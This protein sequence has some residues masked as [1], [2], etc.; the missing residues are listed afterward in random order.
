MPHGEVVK[1]QSI[2]NASLNVVRHELEGAIANVDSEFGSSDK[3]E[4]SKQE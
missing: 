2:P 3:W 1:L 4:E